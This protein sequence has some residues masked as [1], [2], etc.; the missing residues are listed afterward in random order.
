MTVRFLKTHN[1]TDRPPITEYT[2]T[3]E[4]AS[5]DKLSE[6]RWITYTHVA[7]GV[8]WNQ[9]DRLVECS[10]SKLGLGCITAYQFEQICD[11]LDLG[12]IFS[13]IVDRIKSHQWLWGTNTSVEEY[14]SRCQR[15]LGLGLVNRLITITFDRK[16]AAKKFFG[17]LPEDEEWEGFEIASDSVS[18]VKI[19]DFLGTIWEYICSYKVNLSDRVLSIT[20][21]KIPKQV[22]EDVLDWDYHLKQPPLNPANTVNVEIEYAGAIEFIPFADPWDDESLPE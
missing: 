21:E 18:V 3:V 19:C 17:L 14:E 6:S 20:L 16:D 7:S 11:C 2:D 8:E 4:D 10:E 15:E 5:S 12:M 13:D 22:E 1:D 9:T